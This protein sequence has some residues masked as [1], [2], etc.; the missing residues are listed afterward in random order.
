MLTLNVESRL[1]ILKFNA[2]QRKNSTG[3]FKNAVT[4]EPDD[5]KKLVGKNGTTNSGKYIIKH[6][7]LPV[8]F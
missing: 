8:T 7:T 5:T 3:T 1:S 4:H 2:R 6:V